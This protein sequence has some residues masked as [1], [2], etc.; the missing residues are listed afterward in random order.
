MLGIEGLFA[1][2]FFFALFWVPE[3]PRWLMQKGKDDNALDILERVNGKENADIEIARIRTSIKNFKN[4][5]YKELFSART[6]PLLFIGLFIAIFSQIIGINAIMY[7]APTIFIDIGFNAESALLQQ[8]IIGFINLIFT[9]VAI[10]LIDKFGRKPLLLYGVSGMLISLT[11]ITTAYFLRHF[12]GLLIFL[13]I[14]IYIASFAASLGPVS[15]VLISEIFP[16]NIRSKAM[17][18]AVMGLWGANILVTQFFPMIRDR[19]GGEFAFL[20]FAIASVILLI[21]VYLKVP[22]TKGKSLE[23]LELE[24]LR[25]N[26]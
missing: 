10:Y 17:T 2:I 19:F 6:L 1:I 14:L 11:V 23:E 4:I 7:Y 20:I 25:I 18:I 26:K 8:T 21:F 15:W 5:S 12:E 9:F 3:S 22:E 16:N 24:L 13:F